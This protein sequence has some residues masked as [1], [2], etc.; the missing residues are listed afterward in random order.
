[1]NNCGN[2][3]RFAYRAQILAL[4][5]LSLPLLG[6]CRREESTIISCL[7]ESRQLTDV[8]STEGVGNNLKKITIGDKLRELKATC[9]NN[10]LVDAQGKEIR[11]SNRPQSCGGAALNEEIVEQRRQEIEALQKKYTVIIIGC[12]FSGIPLP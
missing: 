11:F 5:F 8:V 1:M 12:D 7:P 4:V 6:A 10:R 9:K 3:A 2:K